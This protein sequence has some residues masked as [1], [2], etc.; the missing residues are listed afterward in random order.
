MI[1]IIATG[2]QNTVQ[3]LGRPGHRHVGVASAGAMDNLALRTGNL[4]LNNA[5]DAAALEVQTFPLTVR[6]AADGV[7]ALTG[8][9]GRATLDGRE[10]LPWWALPVKAGQQLEI[11]YP[12]QGARVYLCVAGGIDVPQVMGSRST[13]LRGGFGGLDGRPLQAGDNLA[14]GVAAALSIGPGGYGVQP[15][16]VAMAEAFPL[17]ADGSLPLRAIAAG[18]AD[19]FGN[20]LPR[21]WAQSWKISPQSNRTGYRLSGEPI[22]PEHRSEMRSYGLV[23]GVVQVPPGGE[24]IVQ[25]SDA[26]TAGGYPKVAGVIE[27]DLWR[28]GQAAIGSRIRFVEVTP[29]E[30]IAA[31]VAVEG[32]LAGVRRL[33]E[34][35]L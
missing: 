3:D 6:F 19:W 13:A 7:I 24:P 31:E 25:L 4:M 30:A 14:V 29:R 9:D 11:R 12:R 21:F 1:E 8:A 34:R 20:D 2:P 22:Q 16:G 15:P 18:E 35:R 33:V 27:A 10:L 17:P 28:L 26:N 5:A 32:Y 23:P